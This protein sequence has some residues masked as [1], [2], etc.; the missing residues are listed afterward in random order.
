MEYDQFGNLS[1]VHYHS[2][3]EN[4]SNVN[5]HLYAHAK[6]SFDQYKQ[7]VNYYNEAEYEKVDVT[8]LHPKNFRAVYLIKQDSIF[9]YGE[10]VEYECYTYLSEADIYYNMGVW[11]VIFICILFNYFISS[12]F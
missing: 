1:E 12:N 3:Y 10:Y 7:N 2:F 9:S 5:E 4:G 8:E 6:Q 11:Y